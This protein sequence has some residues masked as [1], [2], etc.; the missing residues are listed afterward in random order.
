M[1]YILSIIVEPSG[2]ASCGR[3]LTP[4][5]VEGL[6]AL[7]DSGLWGTDLAEVCQ[8]LIDEALLSKFDNAFPNGVAIR[9]AP[10]WLDERAR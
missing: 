4:T 9:R 2:K 6:T 8:R 5:E 7:R 3:V 1:T 10:G